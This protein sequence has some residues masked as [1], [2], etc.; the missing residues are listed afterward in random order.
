MKQQNHILKNECYSRLD[1]LIFK[2][3]PVSDLS[4]EITLRNIFKRMNIE[5]SEHIVFIRCHYINQKQQIIARFQHYSERQRVWKQR[6]ALKG[7]RLFISEDYPAA[8]EAERKTLYPVLRQR[9][10]YLNTIGT[11][12]WKTID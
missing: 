6:F 10:R 11:F 4:C 12:L 5:N 7:T 2:G 3:F 9:N 8:I 1:N